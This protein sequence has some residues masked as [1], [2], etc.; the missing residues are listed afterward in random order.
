MESQR[1]EG[2]S[3]GPSSLGIVHIW[4]AIDHE[5]R[6][7]KSYRT[8]VFE[9]QKRSTGTACDPTESKEGEMSGQTDGLVRYHEWHGHI[10]T[11]KRE[12]FH[13][14]QWR[15]E[16]RRLRSIAHLQ[17]RV[18][19]ELGGLTIASRTKKHENR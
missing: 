5:P 16:Y 14:G 18:P 9:A 19:A 8:S 13:E 11:E 10:L 2:A 6:V 12:L 3:A 4:L 1:T 17:F 7:R 15:R